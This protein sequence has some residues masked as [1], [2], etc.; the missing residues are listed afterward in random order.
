MAYFRSA[1]LL[2][3]LRF[4]ISQAGIAAQTLT[5]GSKQPKKEEKN[6]TRIELKTCQ[7]R[8]LTTPSLRRRQ[9]VI[10]NAR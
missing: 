4:A 10:F 2:L 9:N 8:V 5:Q 6:A 1:P 3:A 7:M